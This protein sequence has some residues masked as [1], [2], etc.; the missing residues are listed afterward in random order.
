MRL[1]L[2]THVLIALIDERL[3]LLGSDMREAIAAPD[4]QVH[5]SVASLWEIAIKN[6]LGKLTLGVPLGALPDLIERMGLTLIVIDHPHVL[7]APEPEPGTRDPFDRL[8]LVQ[9]AVENLQLLTL[10]RA[11][12]VHPFAWRAG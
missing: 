5:V 12:A 11:L 8:L 10:D 6:R 3:D 7:K 1:L 4:A 2:D 9:C